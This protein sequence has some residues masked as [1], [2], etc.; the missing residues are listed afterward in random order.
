MSPPTPTPLMTT[1]T[2]SKQTLFT[3][4]KKQCI[5]MYVYVYI[6]AYIYIVI[7]RVNFTSSISHT[8]RITRTR[9]YTNTFVHPKCHTPK[10]HCDDCIDTLTY[11]LVIDMDST[12]THKEI[13]YL[14]YIHF[15]Q[16]A[17]EECDDDNVCYKLE[18]RHTV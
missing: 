16:T 11:I 10:R 5:C 13:I 3:V 12:L 17:K 8:R 1:V 9:I 6:H 7:H 14:P 15:T 4:E 2:N 18:P